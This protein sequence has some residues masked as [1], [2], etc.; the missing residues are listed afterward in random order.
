MLSQNSIRRLALVSA[1][2]C[3]LVGLQARAEFVASIFSGLTL[4]EN[5]DLRLR[6]SGGTDLTFHD[7]SYKS[8][9]F[10]SPPYYGGRLAYFLP[11]HTH[12]GVG[13]EFIHAKMY[14]DENDGAH[15]TGI[16][17][18]A[19]VND[20]ERVGDTIQSFS[21]S[22]GLNFLTADV[23]YRRFLG[24]PG[25]KLLGH[26]EPYVGAG[27][28]AVIAHVESTVGGVSYQ[29]SQWH[30]P[31]VQGFVGINFDV[32]R[33]WSIFLE[34]KLSYAHLDSMNIP[35]GSIQVNPW[36]NHFLTGLSFRF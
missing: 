5:N 23:I 27:V 26:L 33:H 12:W 15:V 3:F 31:G 4:T 32:A 18:G 29:G 36:T 14:L 19:P 10:E 13:L 24:E 11:E 22:H 34:Y 30:G 16:R 8:R 9:N 17:D 2:I 21:I 20:R 1:S 28:G 6:Q 35:G 7:V 25:V